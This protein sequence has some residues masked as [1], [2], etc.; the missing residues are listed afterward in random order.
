MNKSEKYKSTRKATR[1]R[2]KDQSC[3]VYTCKFDFSHLTQR[4]KEYLNRLFLE[5]KWLRNH[6]LSQG[7]VF[8]LSYKYNEVFILNQNKEKESRNIKYLSSQMK[9]GVLNQIKQDIINLSKL[10]AKGYKI[11][12]LKFK[13]QVNSIDLPQYNNTYKIKN[14]YL[15][16]QGFKGQF[17][18]N[19]LRQIP[20]NVEITNA[21]LLKKSSGYYIAFTCFVLKEIRISTNNEIGLDFGISTNI[22][23]S[24]GNKYNWQF[25][26]TKRHKNL[27]RKVNKTYKPGQKSSKNREYRKHLCKLEYE[28]LSNKKKDA[29]NKYVARIKKDYDFIAIQDESIAEWKSSKM[30]GWGKIIQ[31]SIM[32]GIISGIKKLPQTTIIDKYEPTTQT[33]LICNNKT[34]HTLDK[35]TFICNYCN[36]T[37]DRDTH[38]SKVILKKAKEK[39]KEICTEHT[40]PMLMETITSTCK[41]ESGL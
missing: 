28:K 23:E 29:I 5:A 41:S 22:T 1:L 26:E 7:N 9:Q 38:S 32:G 17:R 15:I 30:K 2:R 20:N 11:G 33:C 10:K 18:I 24:N 34:K 6:L 31:H 14:K 16:L 39:V 27:Q 36:H 3:K 21:K 19:G 13:S 8:E 25:N 4:K 35:R 40:N 37:E 12:K